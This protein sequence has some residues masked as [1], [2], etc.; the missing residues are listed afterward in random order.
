[1]KIVN[2]QEIRYDLNDANEKKY[3]DQFQK[4]RD[5]V[6]DYKLGKITYDDALFVLQDALNK[7]EK[8]IPT[9]KK[10]KDGELF[11]AMY[12]STRI[13]QIGELIEEIEE[14]R[15][16]KR[17]GKQDSVDIRQKE[18]EKEGIEYL[19][20][21]KLI[22]SR[23]GGI[24]DTNRPYMLNGRGVTVAGV[25]NFLLEGIRNNVLTMKEDHVVNFMK[26]YIMRDDK[27]TIDNALRSAF[28]RQKKRTH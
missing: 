3:Y 28:N 8:R 5:C 7:H 17:A 20:N 16:K 6:D 10:L 14:I 24:A 4:Y 26:K 12:N 9:G 2:A 25:Y 19:L 13:N 27:R 23:G 11:G 18:D 15:E 21:K 1:M 22:T